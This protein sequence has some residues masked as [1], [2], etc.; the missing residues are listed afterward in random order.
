MYFYLYKITNTINDKIYIG[1]HKTPD[2]ADNYMGS[3]TNIRRAIRKYG[4]QNF[5]KEILE[6]FTTEEEMFVREAEIITDTFLLNENVYNIRPGGRGS[7]SYINRKLAEG[8]LPG[9]RSN[10]AKI[11]G[12]KHA[13][14][15]KTDSDYR[16]NHMRKRQ[17]SFAKTMYERN[18]GVR[19]SP[20]ERMW[21]TNVIL[22]IAWRIPTKLYALYY[23]QGWVKG[24]KVSFNKKR[25]KGTYKKR[26]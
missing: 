15:M 25:G 11:A 10:A 19:N 17:E 4:I 13:F 12:D 24:R 1:V 2:L 9:H 5:Q 7:F 6:F 3:G 8:H 20:E 23:D 16:D 18:I 26:N 22:N 21:A 14:R